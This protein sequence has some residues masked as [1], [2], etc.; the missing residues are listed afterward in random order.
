MQRKSI[1]TGDLPRYGIVVG[2][3]SLALMA[4]IFFGTPL[5]EGN[6]DAGLAMMGAGFGLAVEPEPHLVFSHFG[7]GLLLSF[8]SRFAGPY[9]HGWTSLAA[10]GLSIG[11]YSR[12]M[13]EHAR[14]RGALLVTLMIIAAGCVFAQALLELQFTINAALLFGAAMSCWL[15]V[16]RE[17]NRSRGLAAVIYGAVILSF[18]I[19]PSA[20]AM[21]LVVVG[22]AL[23]WLAWRGPTNSR[24]PTRRFIITIAAIATTIYLTDRAA[25]AFSADW[26]DALEYNQLRSLF[27]D[28]FRIPWIAGAPEYQ[29]V[30]WSAN[31]YHMF[32]NWYSLHPIFDYDNLK[33][34]VQTLLLQ[35]PFLEPSGV[36]DWLTALWNSPVLSALVIGQLLLCLLLPRHRSFTCLLLVGTF[37]ALIALS[38]T[39]RPPN[40]RVLFPM[41]SL[42]FLCMLVVVAE[43]KLVPL[44]KVGIGILL[45]VGLYAGSTIVLTHRERVADAAA[46]RAALTDAKSYFS[47][48]VISWGSGLAWEWLITPTTIHAPVAGLTI[49]SIGVISKTPI[50][51]STLRRLGIADL[52][53][54]LC[55][56]PDIRLIADASQIVIL[57]KFCEEHYQVRPVYR[58]V[59]DSPRTRIFLSGK[60]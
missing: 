40:F 19:R 60:P 10:L 55:T 38:L 30:G 39:G 35:A 51:Q 16:L 12:A 26:R 17:G 37:A 8:V 18:L 45:C 34:L 52:G 54:A 32:M 2:V 28:F 15:S 56:Q 57:Q 5:F 47:G 9:A 31:D 36:R 33:F 14:G 11:L 20:A 44:Q 23:A 7:Y 46:Y 50:M 3:P 13:C 1:S 25:Y 29:K 59:F 43:V 48:M 58:L 41:I 49:P 6:D 42:G 4:T 22:P 21:G 27:N 53:S 24:P